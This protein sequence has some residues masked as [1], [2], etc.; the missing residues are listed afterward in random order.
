MRWNETI[1]SLFIPGLGHSMAVERGHRG[2]RGHLFTSRSHSRHQL[3]SKALR[4]VSVD[5]SMVD[6]VHNH[7]NT[8]ATA[9][10][11]DVNVIGGVRRWDATKIQAIVWADD[12]FILLDNSFQAANVAFGFAAATCVQCGNLSMNWLRVLHLFWGE[13]EKIRKKAIF[14]NVSYQLYIN[15]ILIGGCG[16]ISRFL[17][18][19]PW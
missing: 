15:C 3:K 7:A 6:V 9:T 10:S 11:T 13:M 12:V 8:S 16:K 2:V 4:C 17:Q 5:R 18:I 14:S 1:Y 19:L